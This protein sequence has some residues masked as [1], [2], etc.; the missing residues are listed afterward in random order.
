MR[1]LGFQVKL[2]HLL[3]WK[4][5]QQLL[6]FCLT[7]GLDIHKMPV[8]L[9]NTLIAAG[10]D[11]GAKAYAASIHGSVADTANCCG[12]CSKCNVIFLDL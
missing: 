11:S 2:F 6:G 9:A 5:D 10:F 1:T 8:H 4:A 3:Y 12:T 7:P